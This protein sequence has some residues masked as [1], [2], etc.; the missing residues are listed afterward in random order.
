MPPFQS[1]YTIGN[2]IK[3]PADWVLDDKFVTRVVEVDLETV[4]KPLTPA[5]QIDFNTD[6]N[7][8]GKSVYTS[9]GLSQIEDWGRWSDG[10]VVKLNFLPKEFMPH[11]VTFQ[12]RAQL[13]EKH[14]LQHATVFLNGVAVGEVKFEYQSNKALRRMERTKTFVFNL[15]S[16][17]LKPGVPNTIEF[18]IDNPVS[19]ESL[20]V[21][22]DTRLLSI[23]FESMT[24]E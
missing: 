15:P 9:Q 11:K 6:F 17:A 1:V 4:D 14:P 18:Q 10:N 19:P 13:H 7:K 20:G 23:G 2:D 3:N 5:L 12:L 22:D 21:N 16:D 8:P 24:F